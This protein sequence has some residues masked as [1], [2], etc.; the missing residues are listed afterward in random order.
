M[1][2]GGLKMDSIK[3]PVCEREFIPNYRTSTGDKIITG[4]KAYII[5][6]C[7]ECGSRIE[8]CYELHLSSCKEATLW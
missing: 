6:A 5:H 8:A 1:V 3:C 4:D 7:P 2:N